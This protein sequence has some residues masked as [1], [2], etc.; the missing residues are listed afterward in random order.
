M[1]NLNHPEASK[2]RGMFGEIA[3]NYD[4]ANNTLSGGIHHLWRKKLVALSNAGGGDSVL[5]CATGTGDLAF[6]FKKQ[7]GDYGKVVGIDFTPE[8][9]E[10]AHKKAERKKLEIDFQHADV[11]KLPFADQSFHVTS[12]S[13]GIRNVEDPIAAL[14]EMARVTRPGGSVMILE[15][16]QPK[17][18]VWKQCYQFYSKTVLPKL[19]GIITGKEDAYRYLEKSSAKFPSGEVFSGIIR[20]TGF[21]AEVT[22]HP[23]SGGVAYVYRARVG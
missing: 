13:F 22:A 14:R 7:V 10:L 20:A 5:D 8:M 19:G 3:K 1:E 11:T 6:A 17:L 2:I 4:R 15:F 23:L 21:F 16:G 12:I 18:P 9:I